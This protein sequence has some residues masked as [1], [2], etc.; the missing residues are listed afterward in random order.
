MAR[1]DRSIV[2][3][4]EEETS[5]AMP[6]F[7]RLVEWTRSEVV[8]LTDAQL[9]FHDRNPDREW[10]W[11]SIRRQVSHM[12][13]S[14]LVFSRRR[15][16]HLL[17]PDGDVPEPIVWEHHRM[18]PGAMVDRMLD[19]QAFRT[20]DQ[21]LVML[22]LGVSWLSRLVVETPIDVL[23]S[24]VESVRATYFWDYVV[25]ALPRG[26]SRDPDRPGW[27]RYDLEGS[28]WMVFYEVLAHVRSVQRLKQ[29]QGLAPAVGLPRVGYLRLPEY[30]GDTK[31]NGPS[32]DRVP[33]VADAGRG[34]G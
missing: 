30:W 17:W 33:L 28:L 14:V 20:V 16:A 3:M 23:R 10:M 34:A 18:G 19:E 15:A 12:A 24:E 21:L 22:Q 11:W 7:Q 1:V 9:D 5:G 4:P 2:E 31:H 25:S 13:W 8:G 6:P 29:V 27:I 32:M 26:A